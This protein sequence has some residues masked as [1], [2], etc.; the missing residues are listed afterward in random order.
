[1]NV[2]RT[3]LPG[4]LVIEP[5]VFREDRGWFMESWSSE[6]YAREGV[7]ASFSQD[8]V[9]F[10][11]PGVVRGLHFQH[12]TDQGK[13]VTA[14]EGEIL[15]VIVDVRPD[16]PTFRKWVGVVLSSDNL[17]QVWIPEGYAHGFVARKPSLVT[18]KTS[19]PY[20]LAASRIV[21][22]DDE[23]IGID[24]GLDAKAAIL[25]PK[26]AAAPR[27][28]DTPPEHLPRFAAGR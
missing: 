12:P 13:L 7:P 16:S 6:R 21:R 17:K 9:S 22:W 11:V 8:N 15:D 18:Y 27:L 14:L 5:R 3:E 4:V 24:W 23:D 25:S 19:A 10:S 28:R 20:D 2:T 1:M 26:D